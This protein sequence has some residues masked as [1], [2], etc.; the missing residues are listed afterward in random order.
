M[1]PQDLLE[2]FL[3]TYWLNS[4]LPLMIGRCVLLEMIIKEYKLPVSKFWEIVFQNIKNQLS[5][6]FV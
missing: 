6:G 3:N 4:N 1:M 2:S 5:T